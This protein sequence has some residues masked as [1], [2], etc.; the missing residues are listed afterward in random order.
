[1]TREAAICS[2]GR[3]ETD[4][5]P[6]RLRILIGRTL[7]TRTTF[8]GPIRSN[9]ARYSGMQV[10]DPRPGSNPLNPLAHAARLGMSLIRRAE[11]PPQAEGLPHKGPQGSSNTT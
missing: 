9:M 4:S 10:P 3:G 11:S 8:P 6:Y 5:D 7:P 1:V 2:A